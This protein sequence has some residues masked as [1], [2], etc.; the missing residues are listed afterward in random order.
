MIILSQ[1]G[2]M[3]VDS[4]RVDYFEIW[5]L[6][7]DLSAGGFHV[8]IQIKGREYYNLTL[9]HFR[10]VEDATLE[11]SAIANMIAAEAETIYQV[12]PDLQ[13]EEKR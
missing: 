13:K 8:R 4:D 5:P 9:G 3:A 1:D 6:K 11:L 2:R 10:R 7:P 12:R